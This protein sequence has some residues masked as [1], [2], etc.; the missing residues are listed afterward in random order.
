LVS[1]VDPI[2]EFENKNPI[3]DGLPETL[4]ELDQ[5]NGL[6]ELKIKVNGTT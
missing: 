1:A 3:K 4:P 2:E 5:L 6:L